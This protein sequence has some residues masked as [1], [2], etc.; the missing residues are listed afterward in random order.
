MLSETNVMEKPGPIGWREGLSGPS[1]PDY[2][3]V[4]YNF[5]LDYAECFYCHLL[6]ACEREYIEKIR[7]LSPEAL[8]LYI[9]LVNRKGPAFRV[10]K[11][12]YLETETRD[13]A[14][15][16]LSKAGFIETMN[17]QSDCLDLFTAA[18]LQKWAAAFSAPRNLHKADLCDWLRAAPGYA[19]FLAA[20]HAAEPVILLK[21]SCWDF[22]KFLYFGR[23]TDNLSDFVVHELGYIN[24]EQ[25]DLSQIQARFEGYEQAKECFALHLL[26][27]EL[28][29]LEADALLEWLGKN[30]LPRPGFCSETQYIYDR[31]IAKAG[32]ML[33]RAGNLDQAIATYRKSPGF[34]PCERLIRILLK[35]KNHDE[36]RA[37]YDALD[38]ALYNEEERYVLEEL[39]RKLSKSKITRAY[40]LL[41][42]YPETDLS[43]HENE[44]VE[45][46][47]LRHYEMQGW[48][49]V[50]SE[51][52]LWNALFGLGFWDIIYDAQHGAFHNHLQFAP[53]NLFTRG[54]FTARKEAI[55]RRLE[56]LHDADQACSFITAV[57]E[58]KKGKTNP[59]LGWHPE[60]LDYITIMLARIP[61]LAL[62]CVLR[63]M[64]DDPG[65]WSH[66]FP[67]LFLWKEDAYLFAEVKSATDRLQPQQFNW[68]TLFRQTGIAC[69]ILRVAKRDA[70]GRAY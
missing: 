62:S 56:I 18:E 4:H 57:Y 69:A 60:T 59:F 32:R 41:K 37:V 3:V 38:L 16:E 7:D 50:H 29:G 49:G 48:Q 13:A 8:K 42:E 34:S 20:L 30:D 70:L 61:P 28:R 19:G 6:S 47:A 46:A 10:G 2:Y 55:E 68:L 31:M 45:Q 40:G 43:W 53:S 12:H 11:L 25:V 17:G 64:T 22:L 15:A 67:D 1:G 23:L 65:S 24:P 44:T 52:W 66:G 58:A 35:Q 21:P 63:Q 26:Y 14:I 54:F 39:R 27:E 51:N 33:E 36:A 5:V 9:R